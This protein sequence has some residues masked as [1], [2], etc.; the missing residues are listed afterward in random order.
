[1]KTKRKSAANSLKISDLFLGKSLGFY[2]EAFSRGFAGSSRPAEHF[3]KTRRTP[4]R[5]H[6]KA[7]VFFHQPYVYPASQVVKLLSR[8]IL[9]ALRLRP[10]FFSRSFRC[11]FLPRVFIPGCWRQ[12]D[13]PGHCPIFHSLVLSKHQL[14]YAISF[15]GNNLPLWA[16][17]YP[18]DPANVKAG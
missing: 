16:A 10:S 15:Y 17:A 6:E 14:K 1:M 18:M 2:L 12:A 8:E 4:C 3:S 13:L 5:Y 11:I 7:R 9:E